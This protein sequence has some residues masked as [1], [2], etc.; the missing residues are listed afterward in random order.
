M[1]VKNFH[2][3]RYEHTP[4]YSLMLHTVGQSAGG[5]VDFYQ[6]NSKK[7]E[8]MQKHIQCSVAMS[9]EEHDFLDNTIKETMLSADEVAELRG[10]LRLTK[11]LK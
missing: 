9:I 3:G 8:Q 5:G 11:T 2:R 10:I 1:T 4:D 6:L 7:L